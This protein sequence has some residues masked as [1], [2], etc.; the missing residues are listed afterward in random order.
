M[1]KQQQVRD[2]SQLACMALA[3]VRLVCGGAAGGG[4]GVGFITELTAFGLKQSFLCAV[5]EP[6]IRRLRSVGVVYD[7][8]DDFCFI[9]FT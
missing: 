9:V 1:D 5:L 6:V 3:G 7:M 8:K 4:E 2:G